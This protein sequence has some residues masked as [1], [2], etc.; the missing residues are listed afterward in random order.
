MALAIWRD[1]CRNMEMEEPGGFREWTKMPNDPVLSVTCLAANIQKVMESVQRCLN[2]PRKEEV[3][4]AWQLP[5]KCLT[6]MDRWW[7]KIAR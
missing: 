3:F 6:P 2:Q 7:V 4:L 1:H 5:L